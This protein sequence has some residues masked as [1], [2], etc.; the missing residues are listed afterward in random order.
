MRR[1]SKLRWAGMVLLLACIAAAGLLWWDNPYARADRAVSMRSGVDEVSIVRLM[2]TDAQQES[3]TVAV[4]PYE[5]SYATYGEEILTGAEIDEFW[6]LWSKIDPGTGPTVLCHDPVYYFIFRDGGKPVFQT[7][8]CW[9]CSNFFVT[10]RL[11]GSHWITFDSSND[12][13]RALL[14]FCDLR[15][16]YDR[17][18]AER[19]RKAI[20]AFRNG[21]PDIEERGRPRNNDLD[22]VDP[23]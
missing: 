5:T 2:G 1:L 13:S 19:Q 12:A 3:M 23:E 14:K 11:F 4:D 10:S 7:S 15:L 22:G 16:P 20:E 9:K 6:A 17:T 8:V 18:Y 21:L